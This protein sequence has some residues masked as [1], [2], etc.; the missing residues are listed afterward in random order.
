[1]SESSIETIITS[2]SKDEYN[3]S[4][5]SFDSEKSTSAIEIEVEYILDNSLTIENKI[6]ERIK[7]ISL[8]LERLIRNNSSKNDCSNN[9]TEV[10]NNEE[11]PEISLYNYLMRI[12]KYTK[13]EE[14]TLIL[15]LIYLD[16]ICLK[17]INLSINNIYKFLFTSILLAIKFNEDRIY[18][19]NYYAYILGISPI[20]LNLMEKNFLKLLEYQLFVKDNIF[21]T[22]KKALL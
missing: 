22:Y 1:M 6:D 13:C 15:S 8:I 11:V 10:F 5:S 3:D 20:E 19:N 14:N 16:K 9:L 17:K 12:K 21:N 18:K 4:F 2:I 7:T